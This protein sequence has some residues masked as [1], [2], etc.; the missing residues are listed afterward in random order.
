MIKA[1]LKH[2]RDTVNSQAGTSSLTPARALKKMR[3]RFTGVR[4]DELREDYTHT[5]TAPARLRL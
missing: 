3:L 1:R 4:D 2:F 5:K